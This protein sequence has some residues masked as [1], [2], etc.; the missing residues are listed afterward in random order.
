MSED[1]RCYLKRELAV[2]RA[3]DGWRKE[4]REINGIELNLNTTRLISQNRYSFYFMEELEVHPLVIL[5]LMT[6]T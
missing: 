5:H 3:L 2:Q 6:S 4:I 1:Y